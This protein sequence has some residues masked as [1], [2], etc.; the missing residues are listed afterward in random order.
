[1]YAKLREVRK[2]IAQAQAVPVYTIFT[3]DQLAQMVQAR[4]TTKASL[5]Q[6]VGVGEARIEKYGGRVLEFLQRQ[7]DGEG[8]PMRR[9]GQLFERIVERDDLRLAAHK[10]LRGK[11]SKADARAF[12]SRLDEES[13]T[14]CVSVADGDV[15]L[16]QWHQ[17]TIFDPK[18]R[19]ITAPCFRERVLHHA[20]MNVCEPVFERWLIADTFA[21]RKG[22]GRLAALDRARRFAARPELLP[23]ARRSEILRQRIARRPVF[24]SRTPVQG[25][26][27]PRAL[28]PDHHEL[29]VGAGRGLPIG[30][31]TSQ[32]FA[33]FYL[34]AFDRFVKEG[35]R[36]KG[37]V[38]YMDDCVLW[39]DTTATLK[40]HR[41]SS[42]AFLKDEL[43]LELKPAFINRTAHGM[44][45]LGLRIYPTHMILNRRS[46]VRF[47]RKLRALVSLAI[48]NARNSRCMF[49]K[50][51][52]HGLI[53]PRP[54]KGM[55]VAVV[56][57]RPRDGNMGD[58]LFPTSPRPSPQVAIPEGVVEDLG[59]VQPGRMGRC[60]ALT[61]PPATGLEV[62]SRE[63]GGVAGIAVV[64]QV[65]TAQLVMA[66]L[67]SLQLPDIVRRVFGLNARR[68]HPAA[69][70][71]QEV[72]NVDCPMPQVLEFLLFDRAR[73][74]TA[75]RAA[76]QDLM[77]GYLIGAD[78]PIALLDQAGGV[79]VAP[80]NLLRPLLKLGIQVSCS[81]VASPVG[82]QVDFLQDPADSPRTDG[83]NDAV[84][85]DLT[86][87]VLAGPV[88]DVQALSHGFQAGQLDDLSTLQG[89]NRDWASR[90][91]G[92]LQ[93]AG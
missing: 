93:E 13:R 87:Q 75:D 51:S 91:R 66:T 64:N 25:P 67:E 86:S 1:M 42:S 7:Y 84:G 12:M 78:H 60:E 9:A 36:V 68:F 27:A 32:H 88:G 57:L 73:D 19:L 33:N 18:Q 90:P 54:F 92:R 41:A 63:S 24:A 83:R 2:Q 81:P 14:R 17:F 56:V 26:A 79:G 80:E 47:R 72:Q 15:V 34:G 16:G 49:G 74:R 6:V 3:N 70:N 71:Y 43:A 82:L 35:L 11:R 29:R 40:V 61:P 45:F 44:D 69:M 38:H 20:I 76:F 50:P 62:L 37:Y 22:K 21:C 85:D 55:R 46:R 5:E 23:E 65:H 30:S 28:S 8:G 48:S 52:L 10:A 4:V 31:L 77:V 39:S 58:E 89:G 59:L 53:R